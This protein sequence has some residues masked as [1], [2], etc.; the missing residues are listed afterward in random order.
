[1]NLDL[2]NVFVWAANNSLSLNPS[3]SK[4]IVISRK[5]HNLSQETSIVL[6][7]EEIQV[8]DKAKN[9]GIVFNSTLTWNDHITTVTGMTFGM[10][11]SLY[12][13]QLYTPQHIRI[14]LAKTYLMPKLLYGCELFGNCDYRSNRRLN[15]AYNAIVRY[16]YKLGRFD[17]ISA[18]SKKLYGVC[19]N[20]LI[21]IRTLIF[22]HKIIYT[23]EPSYLYNKIR[24]GRS[25]RGIVVVP[26]ARRYQVSERQFFVNSIR[27][28]NSLPATIQRTSNADMFKK[29]I[30]NRF[31]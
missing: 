17:S 29:S 9:L 24:F 10:L 23:K 5:K 8:A 16:V 12:K 1:M 18:Y 28:W 27:L 25:N 11:R 31:V 6:N 4:C 7:N 3:K 19:L 13:T 14:L 21:Q 26:V 2:H 20:T 15:V 22:F 30:L